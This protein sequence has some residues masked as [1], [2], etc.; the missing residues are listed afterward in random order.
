M[1]RWRR[2]V[3][4][5]VDRFF[6]I[7]LH[8]FVCSTVEEFDADRPNIE[9]EGTRKAEFQTKPSS[10]HAFF[11]FPWIRSLLLEALH[12]S[13]SPSRSAK[14]GRRVLNAEERDRNP[15]GPRQ[16]PYPLEIRTKSSGSRSSNLIPDS[17]IQSC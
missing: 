13:G 12:S 1:G 5:M 7:F 9:R 3:P 2:A 6:P 4:P 14:K 8:L 10:I 17:K 16:R 11:F 15:G